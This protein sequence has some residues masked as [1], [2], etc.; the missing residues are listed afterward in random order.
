MALPRSREDDQ[1]KPRAASPFPGLLFRCLAQHCNVVSP[2]RKLRGCSRA[3]GFPRGNTAH[4][5]PIAMLP[6]WPLPKSPEPGAAL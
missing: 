3:L 5:A 1:E 2:K 6:L 4:T